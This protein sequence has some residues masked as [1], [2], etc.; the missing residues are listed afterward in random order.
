MSESKKAFE[1]GKIK[2]WDNF[3]KENLKDYK[4]EKGS[5]FEA[6]LYLAFDETMQLFKTA[7]YQYKYKIKALEEQLGEAEKF[8]N[9]VMEMTYFVNT[10][11]EINPFDLRDKCSKHLNKME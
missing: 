8:I 6:N 7:D 10:G 4:I 3:V 9:E 1:V 5:Q 11:K 2:S